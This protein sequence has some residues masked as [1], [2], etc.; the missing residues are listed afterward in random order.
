M[1]TVILSFTIPIILMNLLFLFLG[2]SMEPIRYKRVPKSN[3]EP[4]IDSGDLDNEVV[5]PDVQEL[6]QK[7]RNLN[8]LYEQL[9]IEIDEHQ[10]DVEKQREILAKRERQLLER[11]AIP[12][13]GERSEIMAD[14]D[15]VEYHVIADELSDGIMKIRDQRLPKEDRLLVA[16]KVR[17]TLDRCV[18]DDDLDH[19]TG[20]YKDDKDDN[21]LGYSPDSVANFAEKM[22]VEYPMPVE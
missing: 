2:L 20:I 12:S 3:N 6:L 11:E 7:E 21:I 15:P 1:V 19:L 9:K 4:S 13:K 10:E 8:D 5:A 17:E 22:R 16:N 14:F 18:L